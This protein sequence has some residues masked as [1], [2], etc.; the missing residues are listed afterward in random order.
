M[1]TLVERATNL[2][3]TVE[4]YAATVPEEE[5]QKLEAAVHAELAKLEAAVLSKYA[6]VKNDVSSKI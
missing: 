5:F 6:T 2:L 1:T 4:T 3:K